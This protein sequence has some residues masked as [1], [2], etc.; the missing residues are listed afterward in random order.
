MPKGF[1]SSSYAFKLFRPRCVN[2]PLMPAH[3]KF[4][5][6][7][8]SGIRLRAWELHFLGELTGELLG[9]SPIIKRPPPKKS[10]KTLGV[11]LR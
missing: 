5:S 9:T 2:E 7:R 10:P 4:G 8:R 1:L 6:L 11:R 3:S